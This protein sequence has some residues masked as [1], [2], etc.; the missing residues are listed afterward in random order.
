MYE[1]GP[2]RT[3]PGRLPQRGRG[4]SPRPW[5]VR[6]RGNLNAAL[7]KVAC[8]SA[9]RTFLTTQKRWNCND[10]I[11]IHKRLTGKFH[12]TLLGNY[13]DPPYT[14]RSR[15]GQVEKHANAKPPPG[16]TGTTPA[17]PLPGRH[18]TTTS[19]KSTHN[20]TKG[21]GLNK[22]P[23][24]PGFDTPAKGH[25]TRYV[26]MHPLRRAAPEQKGCNAYRSGAM[27]THRVHDPPSQ[28]QM[29]TCPNGGRRTRQAWLRPAAAHP[30]PQP[31]APD[32]NEP[33]QSTG[34]G[35]EPPTTNRTRQ[36]HTPNNQ[37]G[38][39]TAE[40][41]GAL[42][43]RVR[44]SRCV[45]RAVPNPSAGYTYNKPVRGAH[46]QRGRGQPRS[47]AQ[48]TPASS[49]S[50]TKRSTIRFANASSAVLASPLGSG[51]SAAT[52]SSAHVRAS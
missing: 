12:A 24:N 10:T 39:G 7:P 46:R 1:A 16:S 25:C 36:R 49:I 51:A 30:P 43:R 20:N 3:R 9:D 18:H 44:G 21:S 15:P 6:F 52:A 13:D 45:A 22:P 28:A 33:P 14:I 5:H 27:P 29:R 32:G 31:T 47:H 38:P 48:P 19:R 40:L 23:Q 37:Q 26:A 2:P 11:S 35:S 42:K 34:P 41:G 4:V 50:Q 17:A 8:N